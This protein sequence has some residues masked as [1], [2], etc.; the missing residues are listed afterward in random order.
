MK[1]L[2][3]RWWAKNAE[4][5]ILASLN[6]LLRSPQDRRCSAAAVVDVEKNRNVGGNT[7]DDI[8]RNVVMG[9]SVAPAVGAAASRSTAFRGKFWNGWKMNG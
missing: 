8:S 1:R 5:N 2:D 6:I 3:H 4:Y 7:V 9:S